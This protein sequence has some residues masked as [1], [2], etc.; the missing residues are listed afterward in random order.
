MKKIL[1]FLATLI[2]CVGCIDCNGTPR[3]EKEK[4]FV[5]GYEVIGSA[6]YR[7][8]EKVEIEGHEYLMFSAKISRPPFVIHSASCPCHNK[9]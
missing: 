6:Y 8:I 7:G 1:V 2:L 4:A 5:T 3:I 9:E